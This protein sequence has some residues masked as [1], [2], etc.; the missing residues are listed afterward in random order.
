[1]PKPPLAVDQRRTTLTI[2]QIC[3]SPFNVR[4]DRIS[5]GPEAIAL[6][7][8]SLMGRGQLEP[9]LVHPMR[10]NAAKFGS[11]AGG[12]R[13]RAFKNLV[14][15]GELPRDHPIAVTIVEG[16][17][18]AE[19]VLD[20][21]A[22]NIARQEL[23]AYETYDGVRRA[24]AMGQSVGQIAEKLGQAPEAITRMLRLGTLAKPIF[25]ALAAGEITEDQARAFGATGDAEVQLAAWQRLSA[26]LATFSIAPAK[27]RA[28]IGIGDQELDKLLTFVGEDAYVEAGGRLEPDMF[29]T[30]AGA[31]IVDAD[32]LRTLADVKLDDLRAD[33]RRRAGRP[34]L[35]FVAQAP[36]SQLDATDYQLQVHARDGAAG[37]VELPDGDVV[38]RV[39]VDHRGK[40]AV[41]YWWASRSAKYANTRG[42]AA[43][44]APARTVDAVVAAEALKP[45]SAIGQ[46]YDGSR[47]VADAAIREEEGLSAESVDVFRSVRRTILRGLLVDDVA[48]GGGVGADYLVWTQLRLAM[49]MDARP[50]K[51]GIGAKAGAPADPEVAAVEVRAMPG[52]ATWRE[53]LDEL[54]QQSFITAEDLR[55]A[56]ADY[57][58]S[59]DRLKRLAAAVVAGWSLERSLAA[60]GYV[61]PVHDELARQ[62]GVVAIDHDRQVR[63]WWR[64]TEQLLARIPVRQA[65]AIAEPFVEPERFA[66]WG[67]AKAADV[68]RRLTQLVTGEPVAGLRADRR[69][70]AAEWVHPLLRF[71]PAPEPAAADADVREAAE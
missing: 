66:A 21:M 19:L 44:A 62:L 30:R 56:F 13:Y 27:I 18:D 31:R 20:S 39:Y 26:G 4:K 45:A 41:D 24:S 51:L 11:H 1:M 22:E 48:E 15:R 52:H 3:L 54:R 16:H 6:M 55:E 5:T 60:E 33:V 46:Q 10:G 14:E 2:D 64:P 42:P 71:L 35:R 40:G 7:E 38:A 32:R 65:L 28:A 57:C 23:E 9:I 53:A 25:D 61:V 8:R 70:A 69:T 58:A 12:R 47:K 63:R 67:K 36:R 34:D 17:T 50:S 43:A 29:D 59:D 49:D 37:A 68:A